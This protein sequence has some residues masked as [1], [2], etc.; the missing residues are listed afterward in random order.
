MSYN[1]AFPAPMRLFV[2]RIERDDKLIASLEEDVTQFLG[3]L[4]AKMSALTTRYQCLFSTE[5]EE[6][7]IR[8]VKRRR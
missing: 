4:D 1:S 8:I 5:V 3:E 2:R 6:N 7:S